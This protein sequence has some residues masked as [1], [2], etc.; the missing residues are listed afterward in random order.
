MNDE[1]FEKY[2]EAGTIASTILKDGARE[3]REGASYLELVESIE[4]R[5]RD[6]GAALAF[7]LNVSL[8]E[9]AA[10]DTASV[11]DTRIFKRNDVVKLDLGVEVDGY[12]ADTATTIDLGDNSLLLQASE[13]A[14]DAAIRTIQPGIIAGNLGAAIQREIESR[15]YRPI[16]NLTGHGLDQY[17]LHRSP[18]IPNIGNMSG[19]VLEEGMVFAIEPFATTGSGHVGEKTRKEIYSQI[20][21]RP[22]RIPAARTIIESIKDRKGLPFSRRWLPERKLDIALPSLIRSGVLHEYP[23]LADIPGSLVSQHEHTVIVTAD[24]CIVTTR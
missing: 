4:S 24:G 16:A 11:G 17:V 8:N 15:G 20:S 14:L 2:R 12:I 10:H 21:T 5:V 23:V 18:S 1:I 13:A 19:P 7:P 3:I 6:E 9:D 22:V